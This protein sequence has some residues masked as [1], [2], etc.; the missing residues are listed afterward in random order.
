MASTAQPREC[1]VTKQDGAGYGFF[2]RVEKD[3]AGHLIRSIQKDSSADKAGL[4]DGDRVLRVNGNYVDNKEHPMVVDLIKSSGNSVTILVLD[5]ASY[6]S[7]KKKGE[8]LSKLDQNS[9][10]SI[11]EPVIAPT[12]APTVNGGR[13]SAP[14]PRLCYLSKQG[15]PFGFSVKSLQGVSGLFLASVAPNGVAEKAGVREGDRFIEINGKNV[16]SDSHDHLTKKVKDS[17]ESV[18]F[19]LVDKETDEYFKKQKMKV[20]ADKATVQHLPLKPR[21]VD[22][23]KDPNGYGFFLRQEKNRRGHFVM[24]VDAGSPADKAKLKDYDRIVAVNGQCVESM[25]HEEVVEVIRSG[26]DKTSILVVD[27]KIDDLYTMAGVSPF[28]FLQESQDEIKS[29]T[30]DK[31]TPVVSVPV[32]VPA[33]APVKTPA[34]G[35]KHK[36]K[37]CRLQKSSNGYGFHL[38]AIKEVPGQFI[39][40]VAK[41]GAADLAGIKEDDFLVEV[42]GVNV[43]KEGYEDVVMRIKQ[44]GQSLTL[45]VAS[46]EA[47]EY[48]KS[49]KITINASMADPLP[50]KDSPPS[51]NEITPKPAAPTTAQASGPAPK[52]A[53][54]T[55]AQASGPA[56]KPAAPTTAQASGPA[57]KPAAPTEQAPTPTTAQASDPAPTASKARSAPEPI[58]MTSPPPTKESSDESSEE[59][60]DDDTCL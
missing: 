16:E 43:E 35:P 17:G 38:N 55:T 31:V 11:Q 9:K 39:K 2:L 23:K 15:S 50:E 29:G 48:F 40:Q 5:E 8:D 12:K 7:A 32:T 20:T 4:K 27:K 14:K 19:L 3:E 57:P 34:P 49:Q 54:P 47:Y 60:D 21:I 36:P 41:G 13:D 28:I 1:T 26:G 52:P 24:E 53:A 33:S 42:N 51:Y 46:Q 30:K 37:L 22:L 58:E 6:T 59:E 44:A 18:M 45:L 25:N 10:Q 56:P